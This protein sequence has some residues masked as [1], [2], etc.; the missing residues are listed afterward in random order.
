MGER[1]K[2]ACVL[3]ANSCGLEVEVEGNRIVKVLGDKD[4][5]RSEGYICRKGAGIAYYQHHAA[6]LMH[7]LRRVNGSFEKISWAT[8]VDEIG[9]K[10]SSIV[11]AHGP[12]SLALMFGGGLLGCP[13][14]GAFAI[15]LLRAMGSQYAYGALA[16]ELTGRFWVD[17]ETF[18]N[19][20]L[21]AEPDWENTDFVLMVGKNPLMSNHISQARRRLPQ[22]AK[23]PNKTLV[24]VDPRISETAKIADI[25]LRIRPGTD[26][27]LLRAMISIILKE[28]L[29]DRKFISQHV[30]GFEAVRPLFQGFDAASALR[31]CELDYDQVKEVCRLFTTRSSCHVSDLGVLMTRHSTLIS[32]LETVFRAITGRI[33]MKGGNIFPPVSG[34]KDRGKPGP[35][36]REAK[37]WRTVATGFPMIAGVYPP[38]AMP[39]EI[40]SDR[41]DRL[42]AVLVTGSNP[43]RSYAD[44]TAY[45]QAFQD[46]DLLVTVEISMTETAALSHYVLPAL[47]AYESWDGGFRSEFPKTYLHFRGPVVKPEGEQLETGEIFTRLADRLGLIPEIPANVYEAADSGDR[48][49]FG[50]ALQ[51]FLGANAAA[52]RQMAF[53]L[54]KTLGKSLGSVN[55]ASLWGRLQNQSPTAQKAAARA[56]FTPG[57]KLGDDLFRAVLSNPQGLVIGEVDAETWDHF[58][59][60]STDDG[61]IHLDVPEMKEWLKEIDPVAEAEKLNEGKEEFPLILSSGRH[62]DV[63]ANSQMR[64]PEWNRG[65]KRV[66][67]L[68]MHP[69]DAKR[70]GLADGQ[71]VRVITEAGQESI[72]LEVTETTRPGYVVMPHGFGLVYQGKSFGANAN[73]LAKNTHRDR[74]AGTPLHRYI[75]CR[76]EA[77]A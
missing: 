74:L 67:T 32:Y 65:R 77:A 42:R 70:Q 39:E 61:K 49:H 38:N 31:V 50:A 11:S 5:P 51:E 20:D 45:E 46:L 66:C 44:T 60:L 35:R 21:H 53:I 34:A 52:G 7:P 3:C 40:L 76:V 22:I 63:N 43:L 24:V 10:L 62:W 15:G 26:A 30:N 29:E 6:R 41:P 71:T 64:N 75:R 72:E 1:K 69:D 28:G 37:A 73:R 8:A 27:L 18:G 9:E 17:G 57:P 12:R 2:T 55:Q 48:L 58:Q 16:Q 56:G 14:Q 59:A 25:H 54:A 23:D 68:T 19:Q 33:G 13:S 4:N 36:D 47:S